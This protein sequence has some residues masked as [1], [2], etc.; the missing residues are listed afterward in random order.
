MMGECRSFI[1]RKRSGGWEGTERLYSAVG[2][3]S[4]DFS[5]IPY[6]LFS[7]T[8][9]QTLGQHSSNDLI[10]WEE[11]LRFLGRKECER[12]LLWGARAWVGGGRCADVG[13]A[14]GRVWGIC[15]AEQINLLFIAIFRLIGQNGG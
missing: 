2:E 9:A 7:D 3:G 8:S 11:P 13:E 5:P 12:A 14:S 6:R 15:M 4:I 1:R 10:V